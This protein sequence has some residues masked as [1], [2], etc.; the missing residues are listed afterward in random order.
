MI[1]GASSLFSEISRWWLVSVIGEKGAGKDL[2]VC[3][4][5]AKGWLSRGYK[6]YSNQFSVWN[7]P[8]YRPPL[9]VAFE[10]ERKNRDGSFTDIRRRVGVLTEGGRYLRE[11]KY[12]ENLFEFARK[13]E[14]IFF[15]PGDRPPHADLMRF[16]LYPI[17]QFEQLF[18]I[19]G[20]VWGWKVDTGWSKPR[21]GS[22]W[23]FPGSLYKG[24]Y[25]THDFSESP[26]V[27]LKAVETAIEA[28]QIARGRNGLQSMGKFAEGVEQDAQFTYQKRIE[29][30]TLSLL[31]KKR[32]R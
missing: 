23:W 16:Y 2:L 21:T 22:F 29:Q 27:L 15:F 14:M 4:L 28:D 26:D 3:E 13:V 20:G 24:V 11:Y 31:N 30:F 12:F 5:A 25:D 9:D 6:F 18:G 17:V 32:R 7:D 19:L 8:L 1:F 10:Q